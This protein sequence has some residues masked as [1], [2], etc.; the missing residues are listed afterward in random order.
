MGYSIHGLVTDHKGEL[1]V[2]T[3]SYVFRSRY[4]S[5]YDDAICKTNQCNSS[6]N[7]NRSVIGK[8]G[9]FFLRINGGFLEHY[10]DSMLDEKTHTSAR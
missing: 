4:F 7:P 9:K 3:R 5:P 8:S 6:I 2:I 10:I 1:M